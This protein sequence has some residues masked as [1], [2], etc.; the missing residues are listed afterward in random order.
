MRTY[1]KFKAQELRPAP[2]TKIPNTIGHSICCQNDRD[3]KN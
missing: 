3:D 1:P 2:E